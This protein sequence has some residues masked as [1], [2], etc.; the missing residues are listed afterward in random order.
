VEKQLVTGGL[1]NTNQQKEHKVSWVFQV[2][3]IDLRGKLLTPK[4]QI[5]HHK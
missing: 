5:P 1:Q 2:F 4:V 3:I